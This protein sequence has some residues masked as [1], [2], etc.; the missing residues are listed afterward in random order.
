[1]PAPASHA[2]DS[3]TYWILDRHQIECL[4]SPRRQDILDRLVA[5]GPCAVREF[6]SAVGLA[7]SAAYH[8]LRRLESAGLVVEAGTRVVRRRTERLYAAR[9]PR[10][11]MAR[12]IGRAVRSVVSALCRQISRDF[13]R[14]MERPDARVSGTARNLGFFRLVGSPDRTALAEIN[15]HLDRIAELLWIPS[16]P[17]RRTRVAQPPSVSFAWTLAPLGRSSST[18]QPR[19]RRSHS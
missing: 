17:R 9:A 2:S 12:A 14:G 1:M 5:T 3:R 18:P 16:P 7:P 8:H 6:C 13:A 4:A 19:N 15:R 10:M 11:R